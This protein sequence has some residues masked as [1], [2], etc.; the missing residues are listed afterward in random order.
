MIEIDGVEYL[1]A[2]EAAHLL[3]VKLATLYAYA[4][5]GRIQSYRR[6]VRRERFYRR[7]E[8]EALLR[9]QPAERERASDERLPPAESWIPFT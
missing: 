7:S 3:G 8:I 1:T 9:L 5:R 6:G 2:R 4:S